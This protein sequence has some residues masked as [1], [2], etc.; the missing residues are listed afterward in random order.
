MHTSWKIMHERERGWKRKS[1]KLQCLAN[2]RGDPSRQERAWRHPL[3]FSTPNQRKSGLYPTYAHLSHDPAWLTLP[4][5]HREMW[6]AEGKPTYAVTAWNLS[7][8]WL[9][10]RTVIPRAQQRLS[11]NFNRACQKPLE[12]GRRVPELLDSNP[13]L[14]HVWPKSSVSGYPPK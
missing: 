13:A 8:T 14:I 1:R 11:Y 4:S 3:S 7:S 12:G 6:R 9:W 10:L 5:C 2:Q